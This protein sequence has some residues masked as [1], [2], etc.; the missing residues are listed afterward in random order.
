MEF[1][2]DAGQERLGLHMDAWHP[3][4]SPVFTVYP[5]SVG[6]RPRGHDG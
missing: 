5:A 4:R 6:L 1:M 3:G 2:G